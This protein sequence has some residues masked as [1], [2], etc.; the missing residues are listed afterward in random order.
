MQF[1]EIRKTVLNV[2]T[3]VVA[4]TPWI[5]RAM[6]VAPF[7]DTSVATTVSAVLTVVG[8]IAHYLIA[9]TTTDPVVAANQSVKLVDGV[10]PRS[11]VKHHTPPSV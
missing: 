8:I 11:G 1:S 9:N 4:A 5:L 10:Q 7:K 3:A 2:L 6:E